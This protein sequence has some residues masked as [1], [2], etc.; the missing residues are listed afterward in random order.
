[1]M[2]LDCPRPASMFL[3]GDAMCHERQSHHAF[4]RQLFR[5]RIRSQSVDR[6][7]EK[8]SKSFDGVYTCIQCILY[9][10]EIQTLK[11]RIAHLE[12]QYSSF[13]KL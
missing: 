8:D 10:K 5:S 3:L 2:D 6:L 12:S 11:D 1:M 4:R 9:Q 13:A 7:K